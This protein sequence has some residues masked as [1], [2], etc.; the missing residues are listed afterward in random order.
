LLLAER[1]F[2]LGASSELDRNQAIT[3]YSLDSTLLLRQYLIIDNLKADINAIAARPA[4]TPFAAEQNI[5]MVPV[6]AYEDALGQ[7]R[8]QNINLMMARADQKLSQLQIEEGRSRFFPQLDLFGDYSY[9]KSTSEVGLLE[10]NRS[11]GYSYGFRLR[12]NLFDGNNRRREVENLNIRYQSAQIQSDQVLNNAEVEL[13]K[14]YNRYNT[15]MQEIG[16]ER[17]NLK[18]TRK[19]LDIAMEKY[20]LGG[21]NE[22]DF[23]EIQSREIEGESRLL[24]AEYA[25]IL[26]TL[27]I[28][29]LSGGL[30]LREY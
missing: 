4:D 8:S 10:S 27:N 5:E 17:A 12:Y 9:F 28:E 3:D 1:K 30:R 6:V 21:I 20:R 25:A 15:A 7:L 18:V 24:A 16:L 11:Y 19:N 22:I 2:E 23:R 29:Q 14:S 13:Y 26:A